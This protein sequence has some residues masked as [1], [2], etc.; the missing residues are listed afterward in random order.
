MSARIPWP[1]GHGYISKLFVKPTKKQKKHPA[2]FWTFSEVEP[3]SAVDPMLWMPIAVAL[4]EHTTGS[5][6]GQK[7][8]GCVTG[9]CNIR[10]C[11][12]L[13]CCGC[14]CADV[15]FLKSASSS[16]SLMKMNS[17]ILSINIDICTTGHDSKRLDNKTTKSL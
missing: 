1:P 7:Y 11:F 9:I 4:A 12:F 17:A 16:N 10:T 14:D 2:F 13:R 5:G 6:Y 3:P 8:A 15:L